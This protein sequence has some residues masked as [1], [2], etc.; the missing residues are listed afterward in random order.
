MPGYP[1]VHINPYVSGAINSK[2]RIWGQSNGQYL[3]HA[4]AEAEA[5]CFATGLL[6][7]I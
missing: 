3:G 2:S 6:V 5:A 4:R 1:G 7:C